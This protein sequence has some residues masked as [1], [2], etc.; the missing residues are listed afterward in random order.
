MDD[1][2]STLQNI[3]GSEEG[4]QQLQNF[5]QML[6]ISSSDASPSPRAEKQGQGFDLNGLLEN[7]GLNQGESQTSES[8]SNE[9]M[10]DFNEL[11]KGL[12][13]GGQS[14]K[15]E[16]NTPPLF[17]AADIVRLQQLMQAV[18]QD[19]PKTTLLKSLKPLL[20]EERRH[21]V[22]EAVRIMKLLSLLP[23]LRESGMLNNLLGS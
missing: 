20:K 5:A 6:G 19:D 18:K 1:L 12:T 21:K 16:D 22:D 10:P 23:I 2:T 14:G 4:M 11:L 13:G 9:K 8:G 7:I 15:Q 17:T 3:L